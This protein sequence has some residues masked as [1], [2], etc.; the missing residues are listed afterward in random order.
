M[1]KAKAFALAL[2]AL[3]FA[4]PAA[5][6][7]P[8]RV[9]S[10]NLCTD[11]LAMLLAAPGQLISVSYLAH[12]PG[13]S[14]MAEEA[15]AYPANRG[16]AEEIFLLDPDLVIAGTFTT[17]ATVSMLKRLG[18]P[19]VEFAPASSLE[20]IRDRITQMGGVLRRDEAAASLISQFDIDLEAARSTGEER[21]RAATYYANSYTSGS[22]T[23]AHSVME[24][25]GLQ[26]IAPE[27]GI[28]GGGTLALERLVVERPEL[29]IT[30][31]H[32]GSPSLAEEIFAH[33]ALKAVQENS[34][35][36]PVA[37]REWI[38]GTPFI[39]SAIRRLAQARDT[40]LEQ[41]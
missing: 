15:K 30:G 21:P 32:Q 16:L 35:A 17:R 11:Q 25:A 7:T 26:N 28:N 20:E 10:M 38:C 22:G 9:V 3:A 14:V 23:L 33:P 5:A 40:V 39:T 37:D 13:A 8:Q 2:S 19:V 29:L 4:H 1:S 36:A 27:L 6:E 24:A 41:R 18:I 34:G 31:R 12:R